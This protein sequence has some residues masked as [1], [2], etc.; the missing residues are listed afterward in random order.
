MVYA[1]SERKCLK[2]GGE[3]EERGKFYDHNLSVRGW[4]TKPKMYVCKKCGYIEFYLE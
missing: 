4:L 3:M 2:C 1:L